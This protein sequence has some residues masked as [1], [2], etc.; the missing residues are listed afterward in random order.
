[1][2]ASNRTEYAVLGLLA[3]GAQSGYD[4]KRM[5]DD[6]LGHFWNESIGHI[7]PILK[8]LEKRKW[9]TKTVETQHGRPDKKVYALTPEGTAA[10]HAWFAQPIEP[11][12]PRNE[13]LLK[14]FLGAHASGDDLIVQVERYRDEQQAQL[15][16]LDLLA[17]QV[18]R[19][20]AHSPSL[21]YWLLTVEH[22]RTLHRAS[23]AWCD[24]A[25]VRLEAL[26]A[27]PAV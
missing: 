23:I 13:L 21:S 11:S 3:L 22:G 9:V 14:I 7:Y 15:N 10:L 25:L 27:A 12:P 24:D 5:A 8:R 26:A 20:E 19:D 18:A 16:A 17:E 6:A 2:A 4:I 1:M